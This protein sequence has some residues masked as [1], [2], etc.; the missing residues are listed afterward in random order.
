M[1]EEQAPNEYADAQVG[2]EPIPGTVVEKLTCLHCK[3]VPVLCEEH[4]GQLVAQA[5]AEDEENT[6]EQAARGV[7]RSLRKSDANTPNRAAAM[8]EVL[9]RWFGRGALNVAREIVK[10][11][12][13][14]K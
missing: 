8:R 1:T 13:A 3:A 6:L 7:E 10:Q 12:E 5:F 2:T 11:L 9:V 14:N 4:A